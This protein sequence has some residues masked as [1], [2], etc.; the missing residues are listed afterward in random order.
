MAVVVAHRV[1]NP[2]GG[3]FGYQFRRRADV[4]FREIC[5]R[6]SPPD[7]MSIGLFRKDGML[8]AHYPHLAADS[9]HAVVNGG[10]IGRLAANGVD[11]DAMQV[12]S[13]IDGLERLVAGH[14][15]AHYPMVVTVSAPSHRSWRPG[16]AQAFYLIGA[17]ILLEFVLAAGRHR[18]C[19]ASCA[20]RACWHEAR[21]AKAEAE[22]A[23][24]WRGGRIGTFARAGTCQP[25]NAHPACAFRRGTGQ[26]VA[27]ALHVR[28]GWRSG[29]GQSP[30]E[31]D[32]RPA[33]IHVGPAM[34]AD[35]MRDTAVRGS[36]LQPAD[37]ETMQG[38][39]L[40]ARPDGQAS[41]P[42]RELTDG[43]SLAVNFAPM[44]DDGWLVTLED[45]TERRLVE[46]K[47]EHMAHHDALTGL[48]NR[49]LFR[50]RLDA[51]MA[52]SRRGRIRAIFFLDLDHFKEVNDTLGHPVGDAL[53]CEVTHRLLLQV[54]VTDTVARLGGDEFAIVQAKVV[55][56][57]D[58]SSLAK[59]IIAALSDTYEF[60][61]HQVT[62]GTSI[63]IAIIPEDGA[64]CRS[65][66]EECRYGAVPGQSGGTRPLPLLR[67]GNGCA[68]AGSAERLNWICARR[69]PT[70]E[71]EMFYQ[72]LMNL[73]SRSICGFEALLRWR[74]PDRGLLPPAEFISV[75]EE[76]GSHRAA[77]RL[78]AAA[79]LPR[80]GDLAGKL[81]VAVNLSPVQFGSRTLVDDVAAALAAS[82]LEPSGLNSRS[83]KRRS[84][85]IPTRSWRFCIGYATWVSHR[86]GRFRDGIF[87]AQLLAAVSVQQG[88]DRPVVHQ[89]SGDARRLRCD[90]RGGDQFVRDAG[91]DDDR[92]RCGDRGTTGAAGRRELHRGAGVSVQ[93]AS[94]G[95]GR[96]G[97]VPA[98]ERAGFDRVG[99]SDGECDASGG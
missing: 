60:D 23:T 2:N 58:V 28:C 79:S 20:A 88:E 11:S 80:R 70:D 76:T 99:D 32:V 84:W 81:K 1:S 64:G 97:H 9:P 37:I 98:T 13:Q 95:R 92:G 19:C 16:A 87:L 67:A 57:D 85:T 45:I 56:P 54:R 68:H 51:A 66:P 29:G 15:L 3:F 73:R 14:T 7:D 65:D 12:T 10:L 5:I 42:Y 30:H 39:I 22:A 46:A 25:G 55:V 31:R 50:E 93:P 71:F 49:L 41:R 33:G 34:T 83:P 44:E 74:H 43:R 89:G 78:G 47:I 4:L 69:L 40:R 35:A 17:A 82:G 63:G 61:G 59:R 6:Q 91:D 53:L 27:G 36:N 94:P 96:C 77:G 24:P 18:S 72:P 75:A 90:R 52:R 62:I 8:L 48:P 26:H 86:P 21:A 38:S